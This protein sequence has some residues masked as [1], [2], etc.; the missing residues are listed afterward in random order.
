MLFLRQGFWVC[1]FCWISTNALAQD[2]FNFDFSNHGQRVCLL[3]TTVDLVVP[4]ATIHFLDA[5]QNA[6]KSSAVYRRSL[7]DVNAEWNLVTPIL[8]PAGTESWTDVNLSVGDAWE[9]MVIRPNSWVFD[10]VN[11]NATGFTSAV[12]GLDQSV[13]Q[14]QM[15]LLVAD[16]IAI[17]L[18]EK[19]ARLK[20]D[21]TGDGWL[22]NELIVAADNDW[23]GGQAAQDIR[24]QLKMLYNSAPAGDKPSH[25]FIL[26][27]VP[28][29]RSGSTEAAAPDEH[30]ENKGARGADTYYADLDGEFT[31]VATY[32]PGG[33]STPLAVNQ[34][35]DFRW[36]QDYI[37]S[38][39]ELAF[40]R[41]DFRDLTDVSETEVELTARYLDR[42]H[43]YRHVAPGW[44][45]G[46]RTAFNF[47]YDNSNDGSYRSL[48]NI[49]L[50]D[51][52]F[53]NTTNTN[54]NAWVKDNG[55][56][57]IYMQNVSVPE[58]ADWQANGMD[59]TVF[60]SDQSYW[61]WADVAQNNSVYSRIRSLLAADTKCL[62]TLWTTTGVSLFHH[63]G[64]G[65]TFGWACQ[66][67][68]DHSGDDQVYPK[69]PQTYDTEEWWNRTHFA[70]QGDPT[71][72]LHQ[73]LPPSN[74]VVAD[75]GSNAELSWDASPDSRLLGYHVYRSTSELG[76][77]DRLTN[78][79][80]SATNYAIDN[81][82]P[83]YWYMVRAVI[84]QTT[85]SGVFINPSQGLIAQ[86]TTVGTTDGST[87]D[88]E[89]RLSPNPTT[90]DF[91]VQ[92]TSN[93][94]RISVRNAL[95]QDVRVFHTGD[96]TSLHGCPA[97]V[98][99]V[100]ITYVKPLQRSVLRLVHQPNMR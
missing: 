53:Q 9:Y 39:L 30:N 24:N 34:P 7:K 86:G 19:L 28:L 84:E 72:R 32:N 59:A 61:G 12:L 83:Q 29:P 54:H 100:E 15:I 21:L 5:N 67:I 8:L 13:S 11:Y 37:P 1:I 98:Y 23:D 17:A 50:P 40:G 63:P 75:N 20:R 94:S 69:P 46:N 70:L 82:E 73:V 49:S 95:G 31:D 14:G 10:G 71:L 56:F 44:W 58:I 57:M 47:G 89:V 96:A 99:T 79:P 85:G 36:D 38:R 41:V 87:T 43:Q 68:M 80:I 45:M 2:N 27:H 81:H 76:R 91:E 42:L 26:G 97:G 77:Y 18:P 92:A 88:M 4:S 78:T 25:L 35:G 64:A 52:V 93:W 51:S 60:S 16:N 3:S 62:I 48:P 66:R 65:Q 33:L 6:N 55:P 22:V 90:G 74:F